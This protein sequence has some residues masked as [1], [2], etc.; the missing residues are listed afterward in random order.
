[1]SN[2][3]YNFEKLP[4]MPERIL[5]A[6]AYVS[7]GVIGI[8]LLIASAILKTS[9]KP[10][11]KFNV[12]QS[13]LI[14]FIFAALQVTFDLLAGLLQLLNIIPFVG[15]ILNSFFLFIVYYLMGF[16]IL[17]NMPIL[18]LAVLGLII[19]LTIMTFRGKTPF[20]PLISPSIKRF[21]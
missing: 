14:G 1:M 5:S 2:I 17:F 20:L 6:L 3:I 13:I 8:I 15:T 21:I 18:K 16:P 19:Y 11:V 10:F 12:Y 4:S 9:L 7:F